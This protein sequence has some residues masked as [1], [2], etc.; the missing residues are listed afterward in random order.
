MARKQQ[1]TEEANTTVL[2]SE[3]S[4]GSRITSEEEHMRLSEYLANQ[5]KHYGLVAS[6]NRE[7]LNNPEMLRKK[8]KEGWDEAFAEQSAR[9]YT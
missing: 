1:S 3:E 5:P 8:T 6:F 4:N 9:I 2:T 7:A